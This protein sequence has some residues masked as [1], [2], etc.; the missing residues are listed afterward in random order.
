MLSE[1]TTLRKTRSKGQ[2]VELESILELDFEFVNK[3]I[4]EDEQKAF[5]EFLKKRKPIA[6][7]RAKRMLEAEKEKASRVEK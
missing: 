2:A 1:F 4:S 6:L 3:S 5:S 7:R